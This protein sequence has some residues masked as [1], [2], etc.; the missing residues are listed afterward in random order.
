[1]RLNASPI[2]VLCLTSNVAGETGV[3]RRCAARLEAIGAPVRIVFGE[4][5]SIAEEWRHCSHAI[6]V[7]ALFARAG[8]HATVK[9]VSRP[10]SALTA[11]DLMGLCHARALAEAL[12]LGHTDG[13]APDRVTLYG[14]PVEGTEF[15]HG[16][17]PQ[18]EA[19]LAALCEMVV[20]DAHLSRE[21]L[22]S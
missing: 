2:R 10:C 7:D 1:M 16:E 13:S 14:V 12:R 11:L 3:G 4:T 17:S 22:A 19:T 8:D 5:R 15:R 9:R 18:T 21:R 20:L 6:V